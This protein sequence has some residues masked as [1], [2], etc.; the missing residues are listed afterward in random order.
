M[1]AALHTFIDPRDGFRL[2]KA[3]ES[4]PRP[5]YDPDPRH[6]AALLGETGAPP[7]I[8]RIPEAQPARPR[9]RAEKK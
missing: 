3:G 1:Y 9:R 5:G 2:Y 8:R 7:L 6:T 4:W